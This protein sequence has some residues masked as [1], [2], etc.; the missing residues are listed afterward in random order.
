MHPDFGQYYEAREPGRRERAYGWATAIGLQA[1]DGLKPSAALIETAKRNIEGKITAAEAR[2]IVDAYYETKLG[3][4]APEDEKEADKVAARIN[5]I[6]HLPSFRLSPEYFIGIHGKIFEGVY[7]HAGTI[8]Q[9]DLT[10]KEWVLNG[11]SVHYEAS[12]FIE[13]SLEY[14]FGKEAKFKYKGLSEDAFVEHFASFVSGIWQIHPFREGNTRATAVFAI[15]YLRSKGF[16]VTNDL[17]A[18]KSWYFRNALVRANYENLR[19]GVE[20]TQVPLEEFFKVLIYG[21]DIELRSRHLRIGREYGTPVSDAVKDLHRRGGAKKPGDVVINVAINPADVAIKRGTPLT[22]TEATAALA[23]QREPNLSAAG[24]ASLLDLSPRQAQRILASLKTKAS[25]VRI[26]A[27]K[28][29]EWRFRPAARPAPR[30]ALTSATP[31]RRKP[32]TAPG[33]LNSHAKSAKSA[34]KRTSR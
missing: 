10:K 20:K 32:T 3:H 13:K 8:R 15:K 24:L 34:K 7:P 21:Y 33:P 16:P 25:L 19:L 17:F 12:F 11:E 9:V 30:R 2:R 31:Q 1:V 28:N 5:Q 22:A 29:G 6:I 14:D 27:R 23:I 18:E 26:G 4:D